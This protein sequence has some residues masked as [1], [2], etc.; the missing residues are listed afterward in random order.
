MSN[1][2]CYE[3]LIPGVLCQRWEGE[4][5]TTPYPVHSIH[6]MQTTTMISDKNFWLGLA[7]GGALLYLLLRR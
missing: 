7:I 2:T 1:R 6:T 4:P 3:W 5:E